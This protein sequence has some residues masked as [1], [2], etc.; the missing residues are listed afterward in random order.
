MKSFDSIDKSLEERLD[1]KRRTI[2]EAQ[3]REYDQKKQQLP[4]SQIFPFSITA[5]LSAF[6]IVDNL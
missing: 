4:T 5:I 1:P 2:G 6:C 3:I